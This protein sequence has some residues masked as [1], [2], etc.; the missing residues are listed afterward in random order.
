[1]SDPILPP[2]DPQSGP[3]PSGAQPIPGPG[4]P[5]LPEPGT[6]PPDR[7][8][9]TNR[10][11]GWVL[12]GLVVVIGLIVWTQIRDT[13][14]TVT[15]PLDTTTTSL[16]A[17]TTV[18]GETTTTGAEETTTTGAETTTT[19]TEAVTTTIPGFV[20][21]TTSAEAVRSFV[22]AIA[23][24]DLDTAWALMAQP[25][26]DEV[27]SREQLEAYTQDYVEGYT[28]WASADEVAQYSNL[29]LSADEGE[30]Y[31][32]T[33]AGD[34]AGEGVTEFGTFS[35]PVTSPDES[36][37]L[38]LAFLRGEAV[39]FIVPDGSAEPPAVVSNATIFE[40]LIPNPAT[41]VYFAV[42]DDD[43]S[44]GIVT[45][46]SDGSVSATT[47]YD[48]LPPGDHVLTVFYVGENTLTADAL[49]FTVQ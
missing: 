45:E 24:N 31:V 33:L 7:T 14:E 27:G 15:P 12:A 22:T 4:T 21:P 46:H 1:M 16:A 9:T 41:S 13:G 23:T 47:A 20:A 39:E 19:T 26:R 18:V 32:V 48:E 42:D 34:I 17:E 30:M 49:P 37:F 28:A 2:E 38:V 43:M 3:D 6:Q 10:L 25:S 40:V 8:R 36:T 5:P 44:E 11:L 35:M 29:V